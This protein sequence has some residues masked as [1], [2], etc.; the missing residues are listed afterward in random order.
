MSY[1]IVLLAVISLL[2][3][4]SLPGL[5]AMNV[6]GVVQIWV[7]WTLVG[8]GCSD[9]DMRG[10]DP[11][12]IWLFIRAAA[13]RVNWWTDFSFWLSFRFEVPAVRKSLAAGH[14][15]HHLQV[16]SHYIDS[17]QQNLPA[18]RFLRK[19]WET[20]ENFLFFWWSVFWVWS[21]YCL[22]LFV[23]RDLMGK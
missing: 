2:A 3:I 7:T 4:I 1:L 19:P 16:R 11:H 21:N 9:W 5:W 15:H 12:L 14:W 6:S 23:T 18:V 17:I 8:W 10:D 22:S 13:D 20:S